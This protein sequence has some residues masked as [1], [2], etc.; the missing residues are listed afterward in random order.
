M[1][2]PAPERTADAGWDAHRAAIK[3]L[4]ACSDAMFAA[5][6]A[7]APDDIE[8]P[9]IGPYCACLDCDVRETLAVAWP[10]LLEDAAAIVSGAGHTA[11]AELL[12]T[13][14]ARVRRTLTITTPDS[15]AA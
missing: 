2:P 11:A 6:E 7:E 10:I 12:R 1:A 15:T 14:T 5:E 3:H 4:E 13:E 9:A 8:S